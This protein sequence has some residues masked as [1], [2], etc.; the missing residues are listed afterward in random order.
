MVEPVV[1]SYRNVY[2]VTYTIINGR[3]GDDDHNDLTDTYNCQT[4]DYDN[5]YHIDDNNY[6]HQSDDVYNTNL[7]RKGYDLI[8][9]NKLQLLH[10]AGYTRQF[11]VDEPA[12]RALM[13]LSCLG[14]TADGQSEDIFFLAS[15]MLTKALG[16][17]AN[18]GQEEKIHAVAAVL[19]YLATCFVVDRTALKEKLPKGMT[20]VER[21]VSKIAALLDREALCAE[22]R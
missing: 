11:N 18:G 2:V 12:D 14:N 19:R 1:R 8:L 20:V 4:D 21:D 9:V 22:G 10:N 5:T 13:R 3:K 15:A 17:T 16:N 7:L 6:N